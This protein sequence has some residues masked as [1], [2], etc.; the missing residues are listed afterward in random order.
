[1]AEVINQNTIGQEKD[2]QP[3]QY[4]QYKRKMERVRK[5]KMNS[6]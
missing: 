4:R 5:R 6:K 2:Y 1:M 3:L